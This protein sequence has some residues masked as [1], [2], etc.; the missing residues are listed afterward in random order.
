LS[1]KLARSGLAVIS[2]DLRKH[3]KSKPAGSTAE[4][5]EAD[6]AAMVFDVNASI[7]W[8][9]SKGVTDISCVGA[10]IGANLCVKS[11]AADP[12][13]TNLVLLSPGLNYK[14]VMVSENLIAYGP[15]PVLLVASLEDSYSAKTV[16]VLEGKAQGQK[17]VAMLQ[18]AGHGTKMFN[19]DS[20]LEGVVQSWLLG[21]YELANGE[22]VTPRP[23]VPT[24]VDEVKT[25]GK[26][27]TDPN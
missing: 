1:A 20:S 10:S 15:R 26:K 11:A 24:K 2:P 27:L 5:T 25:S 8:L 4:P 14:G 16:T 6:Y 12:G 17:H 7:A 9:R 3:G 23:A 22:V 13:V 21:T 18:D 19:R